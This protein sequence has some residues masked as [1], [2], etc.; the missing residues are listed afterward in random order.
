MG[1]GCF[2]FPGKA[3]RKEGR[4]EAKTGI[5]SKRLSIPFLFFNRN[6][7]RPPAAALQASRFLPFFPAAADARDF[8][9]AAGA[10]GDRELDEAGRERASAFKKK[11]K[12]H[13]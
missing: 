12:S 4:K 1:W 8:R 5:S 11:R 7:A 6:F 10:L 2:F 3:R 9:C 13:G